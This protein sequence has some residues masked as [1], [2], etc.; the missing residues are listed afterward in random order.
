MPK[1]EQEKR[2]IVTGGSGKAGR[3]V[4]EEL[5]DHGYAVL[6]LDLRPLPSLPARTLITDL[7]DAGQ[8]F[9]ALASYVGA[10][11]A[12]STRPM[13]ID[14]VVH[15]AAIP[16]IFMVPDNEVFRINTLSTYNVLDAASKLGIGKAIIA[17]S[18]T[19]YGLCFAYEDRVPVYLPLDEDYPVDPM[20]SYALSKVVNERTGRAFH[21]RNG[22]DVYA[23]RIG[24]VIEPHEYPALIEGFAD[25]VARRRIVWSYIDARDLAQACRRGIETD[26]SG[27]RVF[28]IAND[29][30]SSDL[31]T[32]DLLRR[33][34]P[35][36]PVRLELGE[37]ET[38]LSNRRA[39]KELGFRP[40][41]TW[42]D[43]ASSTSSS[44]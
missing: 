8:V 23:Y 9:N 2:V 41:H 35:D 10:I 40:A 7:T 32:R 25:P 22:M 6:N 36:V 13:P 24:N 27:F 3:Y 19:T 34:Y 44:V 39:K 4:V 21:L 18:E 16:A 14:A 1:A 30:V 43:A 33:Y 5:V 38:L 37:H 15:L 28:N 26:G 17:S 12:A 29:E 31:P 42:M 20:D 11:D